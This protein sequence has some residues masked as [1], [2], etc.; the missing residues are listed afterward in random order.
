ML[1]I[2]I[3]AAL[4]GETLVIQGDGK[5]AKDFTYVDSVTGVIADALRRRVTS[6]TPINLAY[7]GHVSVLEL[8][9]ALGRILGRELPVTFAPPRPGDVRRSQADPTRLRALF[10]DLEPIDLETGLRATVD[11]FRSV[12]AARR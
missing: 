9:D 8:V 2:F 3:D 7:G 4:R 1:P 5:Q 11:W 10:P 12:S 6:P